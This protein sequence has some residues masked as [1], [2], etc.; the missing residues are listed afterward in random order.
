MS[1]NKW[2]GN[3]GEAPMKPKDDGMGLMG[4]GINMRELGYG[5][6][7]SV[8]DVEKVDQFRRMHRPNYSDADAAKKIRGGAAKKDL[9][10]GHSP[11]NVFFEYVTNIDGYWTC[12]H[13]VIQFEDVVGVLDAL[14]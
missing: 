14:H 5:Y 1:D 9:E 4:S 3:D 2:K 8:S 13:L 6:A 12:T 11:M 10:L 7:L